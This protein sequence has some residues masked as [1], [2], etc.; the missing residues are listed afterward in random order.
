MGCAGILCA[1]FFMRRG[2][3]AVPAITAWRW[4]V[5]LASI[6]IYSMLFHRM[7]MSGLAIA[8][9]LVMLILT[10]TLALQLNRRGLVPL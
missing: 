9:D 5:T 10:V 3:R 1:G 4:V 2:I 7:G 8:S 6:P